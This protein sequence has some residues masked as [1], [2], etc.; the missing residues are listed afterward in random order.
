MIFSSSRGDEVSFEIDAVRHGA[1]TSALIHAL[2]PNGAD[3]NT[4]GSVSGGELRSF[5]ASDVARLTGD[6]QHPVAD[7]D[8]VGGALALPASGLASS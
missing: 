6:R 1:F 8:V 2:G 4:D 3:A 5:V 7:R